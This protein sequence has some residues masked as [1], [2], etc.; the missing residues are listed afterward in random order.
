MPPVPVPPVA[1]APPV[2]G[3]PPAVLVAAVVPPVAHGSAPAAPAA[4]LPLQLFV[5]G[6]PL[7]AIVDSTAKAMGNTS[8]FE[9]CCSR[10]L[11]V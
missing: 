6:E 8:D 5:P 1:F 10:I 9:W 2:A 7:H 4:L 3:I 11:L